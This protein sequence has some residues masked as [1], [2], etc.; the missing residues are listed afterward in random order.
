[1][2]LSKLLSCTRDVW[3]GGLSMPLQSLSRA[4]DS[5]S[6]LSEKEWVGVS[7]RTLFVFL[8]GFYSAKESATVVLT[9]HFNFPY[10]DDCFVGGKVIITILGG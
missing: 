5:S 6:D 10:N 3:I 1:M 4:K 7:L 9:K 2:R 8:E